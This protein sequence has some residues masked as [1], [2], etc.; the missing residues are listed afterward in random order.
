MP[1][2]RRGLGSVPK[3]STLQLFETNAHDLNSCSSPALPNSDAR[4]FISNKIH[5]QKF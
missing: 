4:R 5:P 1:R 2:K 3:P